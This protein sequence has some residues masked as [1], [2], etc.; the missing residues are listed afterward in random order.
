MPDG[1]LY[2][3]CA[4]TK[5]FGN[6]RVEFL[7]DTIDHIGVIDHHLDACAKVLIPLDMGRN[8]DGE[9]QAPQPFI[10]RLHL[11]IRNAS[12]E[13]GH[14]LLGGFVHDILDMMEQMFGFKRLDHVKH[15]PKGDGAHHE[16]V[17]TERGNNDGFGHLRPTLG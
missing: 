2:L 7:G 12:C 14:R 13:H 5:R 11:R 17:P 3:A 6:P 9:K 16:I 4:C 15:R 10:E 8:A 1:S